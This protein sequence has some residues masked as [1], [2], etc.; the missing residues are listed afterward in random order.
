[1]KERKLMKKVRREEKKRNIQK[2]EGEV[3]R[4][5]KKEER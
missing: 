5:M 1:M 4:K 3:N 2:K